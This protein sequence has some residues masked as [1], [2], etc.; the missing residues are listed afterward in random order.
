MSETAGASFTVGGMSPTIPFDVLSV[1]IVEVG[2]PNVFL[3]SFR[4]GNQLGEITLLQ[5]FTGSPTFDPAQWSGITG[6]T[7][8]F[9]TPGAEAP[10]GGRL[11]LDSL[12]VNAVP[13]PAT[14]GLFGTGLAGLWWLRKKRQK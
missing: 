3:R 7:A 2:Q 12:K 4:N 14:I 13:E 8:T 1:N 9:G 5:G 6:F 10:D 11:V